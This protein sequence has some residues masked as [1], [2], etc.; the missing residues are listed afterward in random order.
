MSGKG[1]QLE[2]K[3]KLGMPGQGVSQ[4]QSGS[5][6]KTDI[7]FYIRASRAHNKLQKKKGNSI[8]LGASEHLSYSVQHR[9]CE[10]GQAG[11][12]KAGSEGD[13]RTFS[14]ATLHAQT[15]MLGPWKE[16]GGA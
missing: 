2:E 13:P 14:E 6:S 5:G 11:G 4:P 8:C 9:N 7:L 3:T 12:E 10:G 15:T 1:S 16:G